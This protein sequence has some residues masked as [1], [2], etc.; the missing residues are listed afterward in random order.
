[1][2]KKSGQETTNGINAEF[3][4][5]QDIPCIDKIEFVRQLAADCRF[6]DAFEILDR[7]EEEEPDNYEVNYELARLQYEMGDYYSA[8]ANFE[9]VLE[10]HQSPVIFYNL[11]C[12]YEAN[13]EPDKAISAHLKAITINEN[14]PYSYKNLGT[15]F[16]AK[17]DKISAREYFEDYIK[18]DIAEDEKKSI[19]LILD[20][21]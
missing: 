4:N 16:L 10:N 7:M 19:K 17:G 1:M 9:T 21:I 8:I 12:A 11:G 6:D 15:L 13:N 18:L 3:D 14:F 2:E 20:K 5:G